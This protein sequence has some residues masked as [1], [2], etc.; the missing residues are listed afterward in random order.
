MNM[1]LLR[2]EDLIDL[3]EFCRTPILCSYLFAFVCD[4]LSLNE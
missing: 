4:L 2:K 3:E 1:F